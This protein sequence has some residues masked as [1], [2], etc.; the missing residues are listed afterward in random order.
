MLIAPCNCAQSY[1]DVQFI[2]TLISQIKHKSLIIKTQNMFA[3]ITEQTSLG[4]N[5]YLHS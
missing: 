1:F 4:I 2:V 3:H 5:T